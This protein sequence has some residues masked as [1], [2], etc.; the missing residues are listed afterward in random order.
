MKNRYTAL[1]TRWIL[2]VAMVV[3]ASSL[4]PHP[5]AFAQEPT[6]TPTLTPTPG[7]EVT[8]T[9]VATMASPLPTA[10]PIPTSTPTP[11]REVVAAPQPTALPAVAAPPV[12]LPE[13]GRRTSPDALIVLMLGVLVLL[14]ASALAGRGEQHGLD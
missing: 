8:K 12:G 1:L 7:E 3:I 11:P 2:T 9:P 4:I 6:K 13:T 14:G 5:S 10:T